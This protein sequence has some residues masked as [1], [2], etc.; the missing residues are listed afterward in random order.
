MLLEAIRDRR[1]SG[2]RAFSTTTML[3]NQARA[4]DALGPRLRQKVRDQEPGDGRECHVGTAALV[5]FGQN[6]LRESGEHGAGRESEQHREQVP[7]R[8]IQEQSPHDHRRRDEDR[9]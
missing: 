7:G 1:G 4:V 6:G 9:G 3:G 8:V 5:R 2:E